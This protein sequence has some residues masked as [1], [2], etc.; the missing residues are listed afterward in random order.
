MTIS[1][2]KDKC[3]VEL[4]DYEINLTAEGLWYKHIMYCYVSTIKIDYIGETHMTEGLRLAKI[5]RAIELKTK[6]GEYEIKFVRDVKFKKDLN[7]YRI[8]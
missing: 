7:S 8:N 3:L 5:T 1:V 4:E 6:N 2:T